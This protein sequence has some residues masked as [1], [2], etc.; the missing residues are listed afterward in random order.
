[1]TNA[2]PDAYIVNVLG[3]TRKDLVSANMKAD[4]T[5]DAAVNTPITQN[6]LEEETDRLS[7]LVAEVSNCKAVITD[8]TPLIADARTKLSG[9]KMNSDDVLNDLDTVKRRLIQAYKSRSM[10]PRVFIKLLVY[11]FLI[12]AGLVVLIFLKSLVP[13]SGSTRSMA[14]GVLACA[15]WGCLGGIVDAFQALIEHFTDQNFDRQFQSWYFLHPLMGV[16]LG[17]VVYLI[18]QAGLASVGNSVATTGFCHSSGRH[19]VIVHRSR[20]PGRFQTDLRDCFCQRHRRFN[21]QQQGFCVFYRHK[22]PNVCQEKSLMTIAPTKI[23]LITARKS[24]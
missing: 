19:H 4:G 16:S 17:A 18:F 2:E 9:D 14:A 7:R 3:K 6:N 8:C 12:A 1:M 24:M 13:D 10:W 20:I 11:N 5:L 21:F 23:K 22:L 15:V